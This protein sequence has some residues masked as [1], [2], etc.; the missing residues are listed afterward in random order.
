MIRIGIDLGGTNVTGVRL[1]GDEI[2]GH[3]KVATPAAGPDAVVDAIAALVDGELGGAGG[4]EG[5][6]VGAP[7]LIDHQRGMVL[8]APNLAGWDRP[9]PLRDR[10]AERLGCRVELDND[11]NVG[12]LAEHRIGAGAGAGE[13]LAVF[14]G[15]GVGAGVVLDDRLRRGAHGH[16]GELGHVIVED[17]GRL[18]GCGGR[19]HLEAYAGRA[20]IEAEARRRH[21]DGEPTA[22]VELAGDG[23]VKSKVLARALEQGDRLA[24]ELLDDAVRALGIAL[25]GAVAVL[26]VELIVVGGG[27][28]DRLGPGFVGRVEQAVRSRSFGAPGLRVV[29]AALGDRAGPLGAALLL[30]E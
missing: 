13:L 5:V 16:A 4:A 24:A 23:P 7:G 22:L 2:D 25:A 20:S 14:V 15:T 29:P 1:D 3:G 28:P 26:D 8:A 10:L 27:V 11:V 12:A 30:G 21:A 19:G 18:C 6:G 17:G 9:V